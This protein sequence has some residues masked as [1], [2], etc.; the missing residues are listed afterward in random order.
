[1]AAGA[2]SVLDSSFRFKRARYIWSYAQ[3]AAFSIPNAIIS[4]EG[5]DFSSFL[6]CL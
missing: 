4:F 2:T 5:R 1:M 6:P 3:F